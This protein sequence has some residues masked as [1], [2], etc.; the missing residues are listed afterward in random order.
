[1]NKIQLLHF[2]GNPRIDHI[3]MAIVGFYEMLFPGRISGY[4]L[5]GSYATGEATTV[6]DID[7]TPLFRGDYLDTDERQRAWH[8][9]T[10]SEW[11]L[12]KSLDITPTTEAALSASNVEDA[13]GLTSLKYGSTLVYGDDFRPQIQVPSRWACTRS[14]FSA[15]FRAIS[16]H[17][18][19]PKPL[20]FPLAYPDPIQTFYG[21]NQAGAVI[22]GVQTVSTE[23][24]VYAV[25]RI[26]GALVTLKTDQALPSKRA[27]VQAY[28]DLIND[29]W[30]DYAAATFYN[31]H[32]RWQYAIPHDPANRQL[33]QNFYRRALAFENHFLRI[34]FDLLVEDL[35]SSEAAI[36]E[37]AALQLAGIRKQ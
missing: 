7:L 34:Y 28:N 15:A 32:D 20:I 3:L 23:R 36:R 35:G 2:T 21:Y 1:M 8:V 27:I 18:Y 6:S 12:G 11:M 29:E 10:L 5:Q 13:I 30:A 22:D 9:D 33:L 31:C 19:H 4:Y 24:L 14:A 37:T 25:I 16:W 17:H 26:A